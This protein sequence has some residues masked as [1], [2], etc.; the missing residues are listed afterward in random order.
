MKSPLR[1][2]LVCCLR[3]SAYSVLYKRKRGL[4]EDE[5]GTKKNKMVGKDNLLGRRRNKNDEEDDELEQEEDDGDLV[6]GEES[7]GGERG[8]KVEEDSFEDRVD[9]MEEKDSWMNNSESNSCDSSISM[10]IRSVN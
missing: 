9:E 1:I 5:K 10:S 6:M 8:L 4:E 7:Q 2:K 3:A